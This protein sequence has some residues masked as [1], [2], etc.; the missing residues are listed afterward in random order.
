M[1]VWTDL[2]KVKGQWKYLY[3][4]VDSQGNTL[5]F[6]LCTKR[7]ASAAEQFLRKTLSAAHTQPPWVI[8]VVEDSPCLLG[9]GVFN[10]NQA[11]SQ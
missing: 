1:N 4:A 5:D 7:D 2:F 8:N 9:R 11:C 10:P 6:L 3:R